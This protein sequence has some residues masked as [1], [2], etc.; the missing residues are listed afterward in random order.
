MSSRSARFI[1]RSGLCLAGLSLALT[2]TGTS[3]AFINASVGGHEGEIDVNAHFIGEFGKVEPTERPSTWQ[4]ANVKI[5]NVGA[6]YTIGTLGPLSEFYV[7]LD[8][9]YYIAGEEIIDN[10]EDEL[11]GT[12]LFD[13]DKG[14]YITATIA[15]NFV[16]EPRFAFGG[17]VQGT[18]PIDVNLQK[19]S[20]VHLHW[21]G[22]GTSLGVF[23]TDPT[24]LV[25]LAFSNRIFIGSGAYDGDVQHNASVALTNL[26]V[27]EFARWLLPWRM[28]VSIGPYFE[29]DINE[30]VNRVYH[31]A[32]ARVSPD[33]VAGDRVR[34]MR[35]AVAVLPY[36]RVTDHAALELGYVQQ[37]FGYDPRATQFWS[38]GIRV[39]F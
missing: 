26:F 29:G 35:F 28:G 19:F 1:A 34:A 15:T 22:G 8:G 23:L 36:F 18:I 4:D 20:N 9:A 25:R 3:A 32:Y 14:G 12:K 2:T 10:P 6:G 24:K 39:S 37:L 27:L 30:S 13:E 11:F 38:A 16:H 31:D 7:R 21:V 33:L 5:F 17:F